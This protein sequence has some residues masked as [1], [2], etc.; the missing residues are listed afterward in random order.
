[1]WAEKEQIDEA[2]EEFSGTEKFLQTAENIC[3]PY[4]W[5]IYDLL[6]MPPSVSIIFN[7]LIFFKWFV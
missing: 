6:V 1:M 7:R 2:A 5:K 4:V 3:G